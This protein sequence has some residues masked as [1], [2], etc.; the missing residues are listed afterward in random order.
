[1]DA[2][3]QHVV[4]LL[5]GGQA[6]DTFDHVLQE[7]KPEDRG[8]VPTGA[9]QSAWQIVEHMRLALR[10]ILDYS[11]NENGTYR[12]KAWPI[13]YWP[14]SRLPNPKAWDETV[15]AYRHDLAE[16]EALVSDESRDL[17]RP[18]PWAE[19]HTLLREA[20]LAADHAAYH[21]GQLIE[22]KRWIEGGAEH[23]T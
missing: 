22:L 6:F 20:L 9:E 12:E 3:R 19:G 16:L 23:C 13:D 5:K 2:I 8:I 10:D 21:L 4:A 17:F 18:F 11:Q 7:F 1:V 15:K 14:S